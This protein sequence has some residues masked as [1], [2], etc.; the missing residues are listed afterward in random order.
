[1]DYIK[2]RPSFCIFPLLCK[3][4]KSTIMIFHFERSWLTNKTPNIRSNEA[5]IDPWIHPYA[6]ECAHIQMHTLI[7]VYSCSQYAHTHAQMHIHSENRDGV[8]DWLHKP[9][10]HGPGHGRC[11]KAAFSLLVLLY[12]TDFLF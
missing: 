5:D 8:R 2:N 10:M 9:V 6:H 3:I 4:E 12:S 1:M 11:P 7:K